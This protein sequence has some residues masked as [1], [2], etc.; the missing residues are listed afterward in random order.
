MPGCG[1]PMQSQ[2]RG[3]DPRRKVVRTHHHD[4][5]LASLPPL[6]R[7]NRLPSHPRQQGHPSAHRRQGPC[8]NRTEPCNSSEHGKLP[9][10]PTDTY[11][12]SAMQNQRPLCCA[13]QRPSTQLVHSPRRCR[14]IPQLAPIRP[15]RLSH[16]QC[17]GQFNF[18][19]APAIPECPPSKHLQSRFPKPHH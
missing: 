5:P 12:L 10:L 8:R 4:Y 7:S 17:P 6:T 2:S 18:E 1:L 3:V 16:P 14:H 15:A 19:Q 11:S 13:Q 9:A